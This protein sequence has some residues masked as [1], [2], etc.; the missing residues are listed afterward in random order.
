MLKCVDICKINK[1]KCQNVVIITSHNSKEIYGYVEQ[2]FSTYT[3]IDSTFSFCLH[4]WIVV[5]SANRK[6]N[7]TNRYHGYLLHK[8][9]QMHKLIIIPLFY[10]CL[11]LYYALQ[12]ESQK[13]PSPTFN[14]LDTPNKGNLASSGVI[15]A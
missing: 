10:V 15:I 9:T 6:Y 1:H 12:S 11:W 14:S 13:T 2:C 5:A 4:R 3:I 8:V 7:I